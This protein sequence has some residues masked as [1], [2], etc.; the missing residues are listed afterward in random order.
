MQTRQNSRAENKARKNATKTTTLLTFSKTA[1]SAKKTQGKLQTA[2]KNV[3]ERKTYSGQ[4]GKAPKG[5]RKTKQYQRQANL[6][7]SKLPTGQQFLFG[8]NLKKK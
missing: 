4:T 8:F 7:P 1:T 5:P 2:A 3:F 6:L